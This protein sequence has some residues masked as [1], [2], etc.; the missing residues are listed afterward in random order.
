[1]RAICNQSCVNN[2]SRATYF[3]SNFYGTSHEARS[4]PPTSSGNPTSIFSTYATEAL[5]HLIDR[6]PPNLFPL[7]SPLTTSGHSPKTQDVWPWWLRFNRLLTGTRNAVMVLGFLRSL[8]RDF[9]WVRTIERNVGRDGGAID[10]GDVGG[11]EVS[12]N[13]LTRFNENREMFG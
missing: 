4:P 10:N 6:F 13:P 1:M 9:A 5:P 11:I 12:E 7:I 2:N 3:F 8:P